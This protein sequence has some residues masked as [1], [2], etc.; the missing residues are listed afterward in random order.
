MVAWSDLAKEDLKN[1][2]DYIA[3]DSPFYAHKVV[4]DIIESSESLEGFPA[5]GRVVP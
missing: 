3:Q 1:I 4:D 5:S 2:Y